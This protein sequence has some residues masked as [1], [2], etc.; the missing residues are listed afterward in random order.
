MRT[1]ALLFIVTALFPA[2]AAASIIMP[3]SDDALAQRADTIVLG[4]VLRTHTM[5]YPDGFVATQAEV[6]VYRGLRGARQGQL[7]IV[8][9]PGGKLANGLTA[10]VSGSPQL[11]PGQMIMVFLEKHGDTHRPLGM[12]FGL[13]RVR[14][15][16]DGAM[17]LYRDLEG[18]QLM[19]TEGQA[20]LA[21][22]FM[23]EGVG[24][25]E[26]LTRVQSALE[27]AGIRE[28]KP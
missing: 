20:V 26:Y 3:L 7:L 22:P 12:S 4:T 5:Q 15:G 14:H 24:L 2:T 11:S 25:D 9:V 10:V 8:E 27:R 23:L 17:R 16:P 28:V 19:N 13:L 21:R 18:L 1:W 6:Q